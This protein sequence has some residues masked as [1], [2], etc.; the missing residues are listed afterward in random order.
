M[1]PAING[2]GLILLGYVLFHQRRQ[3]SSMRLWT[4]V[5]VLI[6][7]CFYRSLGTFKYFL[8]GFTIL[9]MIETFYSKISALALVTLVIAS[10]IFKYFSEVFTFPIRLRLTEL[11]SW[12]VSKIEAGTTIEG[13]LIHSK[14]MDFTVDEACSGLQMMA[15]SY[16]LGVFWIAFFQN[17]FKVQFRW[18]VIAGLMGVIL[19]LNI[20]CNLNRIVLLI[21][22]K[23]PPNTFSHE[24]IGL[25]CL[26]VYVVLPL[27]L[28]N[29]W[30]CQKQ[31]WAQI[32]F[33]ENKASFQLLG[34]HKWALAVIVI[35]VFGILIKPN[36]VFQYSFRALPF[37]KE[38][39]CKHSS[40]G[41]IQF[42]NQ[43][44]L[45]Y[46][47]H[48]PSFY[49]TE[50]N[51]MLCWRGSGYQLGSYMEKEFGHKK[52]YVSTLYKGKSRLYT[53]WWFSNGK[54][55]TNNQLDF[56]WRMLKAEPSFYVVNVTASSPSQ[57]SN[58]ICEWQAR[59]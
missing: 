17:R 23:S 31:S 41:V 45:V 48:I 26:T 34:K 21:L 25:L 9:A 51:P 49:N 58:S 36:E 53:A 2:F 14:S 6:G 54:H 44:S 3:A 27:F 24:L 12:L 33:A 19:A 35:T 38:Y 46:L 42:S 57:L 43:S 28:I 8:L 40:H 55:Q 4:L 56:R 29:K 47:K 32:T 20:M 37:P 39:V 22:L 5:I 59:F 30:L 7:L 16:F 1:I 52:V 11:A 10:P 50:H 18:W 13:N 15:F